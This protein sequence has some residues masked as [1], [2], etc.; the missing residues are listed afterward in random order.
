ML[1]G[2]RQWHRAIGH[3]CKCTCVFMSREV[4]KEEREGGRGV[5]REGRREGR[6]LCDSNLFSSVC[7]RLKVNDIRW[8]IDSLI[9]GCIERL[10]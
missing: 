3:T 5:L 7:G 2:C 1:C 10:L 6:G 4:K 8:E 9:D